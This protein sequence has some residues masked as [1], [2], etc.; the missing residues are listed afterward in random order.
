MSYECHVHP[1]SSN[2]LKYCAAATDSGTHKHLAKCQQ[3]QG[4]VPGSSRAKCQ[5]AAGPSARQ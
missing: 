3:Q 4:Q 5:E 2:M 1:A